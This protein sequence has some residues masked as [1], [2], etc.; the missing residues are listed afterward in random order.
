MPRETSVVPD[1]RVANIVKSARIE[2]VRVGISCAPRPI[3]EQELMR[4]WK[5][6]LNFWLTALRVDPAC[7]DLQ[8]GGS[9]AWSGAYNAIECGCEKSPAGARFSPRCR[10]Q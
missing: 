3:S 2:T 7:P 1:R 5:A 6:A 9:R 8:D 4:R 10:H